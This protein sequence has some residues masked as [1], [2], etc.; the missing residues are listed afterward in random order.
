MEKLFQDF[1][2]NQH[3]W[4][5]QVEKELKGAPYETL[6]WEIEE[7]LN[8]EPLYTQTDLEAEKAKIKSIQA[9]QALRN[10]S[11]WLIASDANIGKL[12]NKTLLNALNGG[13]EFI[14]LGH[15]NTKLKTLLENV[16]PDYIAIAY[17]GPVK[18]FEEL[19]NE[20]KGHGT[21]IAN[22][23]TVHNYADPISE[24]LINNNTPEFLFV[25]QPE[26][27][28]YTPFAIR[29]DYFAEM[30]LPATWQIA[31]SLWSCKQ[32]LENST[33]SKQVTNTNI[34]TGFGTHFFVDLAKFRA[35][36]HLTNQLLK[37]YDV[38][39]NVQIHAKES[40]L[41]YTQKDRFN[42]ILRSTTGSMSAVLGGADV[43]INRAHGL[44]A[45][46]SLDFTLRISKNIQILLKEES[47]LDKVIDPA[48]GSYYVEKLTL[49]MVEKAWANFLNIEA[50]STSEV[51]TKLKDLSANAQAH[52]KEQYT[53]K[54][55]TLLG[56][57]K[58]PNNIE[59]TVEST[60]TEVFANTQK[61]IMYN[62][63]KNIG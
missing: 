58:F 1:A 6:L 44:N 9:S 10:T 40:A 14:V 19:S 46:D 36:R 53:T 29:G 12:A 20:V 48:A 7:D 22:A 54:A 33:A 28:T 18:G 47:Y 62:L 52:L 45:E 4:K 38:G 59:K 11:S 39:T 21:E 60:N 35:L 34:V 50:L 27:G 32:Y 23:A 24:G 42:N 15:E 51:H 3:K 8:V 16:R 56:I 43:L 5:A 26:I 25:P 57:N 41:Y 2:E 31:F 13:V 37:A 49:Q 30:A 63:E 61:A 55:A 17:D